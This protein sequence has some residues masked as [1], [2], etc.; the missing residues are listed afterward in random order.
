MFAPT[1]LVQGRYLREGK[2]FGGLQT[3]IICCVKQKMSV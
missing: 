3:T 2:M 1:F